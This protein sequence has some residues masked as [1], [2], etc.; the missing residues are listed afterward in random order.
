MILKLFNY[1]IMTDRCNTHTHTHTGPAAV[2]KDTQI[3]RYQRLD[4]EHF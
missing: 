2:F 1:L 3:I 4:C